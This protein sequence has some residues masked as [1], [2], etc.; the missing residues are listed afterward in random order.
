MDDRKCSTDDHTRCDPPSCAARRF[1]D[2]RELDEL[3]L[4]AKA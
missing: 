3:G 2:R 4:T 1:L